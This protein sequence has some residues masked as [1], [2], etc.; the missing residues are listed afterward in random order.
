MH[1]AFIR[2]DDDRED[3]GPEAGLRVIV[4]VSADRAGM[5]VVVL[6]GIL[7]RVEEVG[8]WCVVWCWCV[9]LDWVNNR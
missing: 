2:F 8:V 6:E 1:P 3:G 4:L 7:D 5:S 9:V